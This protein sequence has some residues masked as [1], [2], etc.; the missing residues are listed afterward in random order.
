MSN[1]EIKEIYEEYSRTPGDQRKSFLEKQD[2]LQS[3]I[4]AAENGNKEACFLVGKCFDVGILTKINSEKSAQYYL[5]G[6]ELEEPMCQV[7]ISLLLQKGKGIAKDC[8]RSL[9]WMKKAAEQSYNLAV[10]NLAIE[11][12][13]GLAD[14][15]VVL[16]AKDKERAL[17]LFYEAGELGIPQGYQMVGQL[18]SGSDATIEDLQKAHDAYVKG[19]SSKAKAVLKRI[20]EFHLQPQIAKILPLLKSK[21][22]AIVQQGLELIAASD[23]TLLDAIG[24]GVELDEK[25]EVTSGKKLGYGADMANLGLFLLKY[26]DK[27]VP[28][29]NLSSMRLVGVPNNFGE[30]NGVEELDMQTVRIDQWPESLKE[31]ESLRRLD[32][33]RNSIAEIPDV[34]G[35]F[36]NMISLNLALNREIT[37]I[38]P[39]IGQMRSLERL[40][41]GYNNLSSLPKEITNLQSLRYLG[42]GYNEFS[43]LPEFLCQLT[44]LESLN[45]TSNPLSELPESLAQ[46]PNLKR[47]FAGYGNYDEIAASAAAIFGSKVEVVRSGWRR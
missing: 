25:G 6:A 39:S 42:L 18:L 5:K 29:L 13:N 38:P 31:M 17:E 14:G 12:L 4:T 34:L 28:Y 20:E 23:E 32:L 11:N 43:V 21:D 7:N 30:L 16:I 35:G 27:K 22:P 19:N 2:A 44:A 24:V 47:I 37:Q 46:L 45:V 26:K 10:Y 15:D 40:Y 41:L 1:Q 8:K 36:P 9:Y 33:N 3:W